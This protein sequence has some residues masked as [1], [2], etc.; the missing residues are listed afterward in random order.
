MKAQQENQPMTTSLQ[1]RS[2]RLLLR[3]AVEVKRRSA[4]GESFTEQ[5]AT[6]ALNAHGALIAI[7]PPV[8]EGEQL[9]VK[10]VKTG[11]QQP[12]RIVYIGESGSDGVQVGIEFL[13]PSPQ[14]WGVVFPPEDWIGSGRASQQSKKTETKLNT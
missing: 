11:E 10:N 12:S 1:R 2:R 5:S 3:V 6:L 8:L 4:N 14:M 13:S 9:T 7:K